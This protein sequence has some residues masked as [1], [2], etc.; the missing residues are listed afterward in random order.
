M[1]PSVGARSRRSCAGS[2]SCPEPDGPSIEKNSPSRDVEVD[3][4]DRLHVAEALDR[5]PRGHRSGRGIG[6]DLEGIRG[7]T[8][9]QRS[10]RIDG[11]LLLGVGTTPRRWA[12]LLGSRPRIGALCRCA[13]AVSSRFPQGQRRGNPQG[14]R[15]RPRKPPKRRLLGR[16]Q[17][18]HGGAGV[19]LGGLGSRLRPS[20]PAT[21]RRT[22]LP[23]GQRA[24]GCRPGPGDRPGGAAGPPG[25]PAPAPPA[26]APRRSPPWPARAAA[27]GWPRCTA[28]LSL[29]AWAWSRPCPA[30]ARSRCRCWSASLPGVMSVPLQLAGIAWRASPRSP[31]EVR[32]AQ[33]VSR[34][35]SSSPAWP[36]SP[37]GR[38]TCC[39]TWRHAPRIRS[40]GLVA[41]RALV[42]RC[43]SARRRLRT[44]R[45]RARG[46]RSSLL[47]GALD[48]GGNVGSSSSP[49]PV[50][51][52]SPP[53]CRPL[54]PRHMLLARASCSARP[55]RRLGVVAVGLAIGAV[56]LISLGLTRRLISR[57]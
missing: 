16:P 31:P 30:L 29:G 19:D 52:G 23:A 11:H 18:S 53:R 22:G 40:W 56:A 28:G 41:S 54:S 44:G 32:R 10:H 15:P 8:M 51:S 43:S 21:S 2:S 13:A 50:R 24:D 5:A 35:R 57:R 33:G 26:P 46:R 14:R 25:R 47:A 55:C 27:S 38:G 17:G 45:P 12:R 39:S 36:P 48:V 34:E 4:G 42:P 37:S 9:W 7:A 20:A 49:A 1:R 6:P 3:A